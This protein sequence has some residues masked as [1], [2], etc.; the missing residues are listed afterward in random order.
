[1]MAVRQREKNETC[2]ERQGPHHVIK[3]EREEFGIDHELG[4]LLEE[5]PEAVEVDHDSVR[6]VGHGDPI[7][8]ATGTYENE[9]IQLEYDSLNQTLSGSFV[10]Y[11]ESGTADVE[12]GSSK[13]FVGY[14]ERF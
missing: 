4:D 14:F 6:I 7:Y 8:T 2:D 11:T 5:N 9:E 1:M 12:I 3:D 10:E 13:E